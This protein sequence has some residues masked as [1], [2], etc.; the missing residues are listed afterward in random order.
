MTTFASF[1]A[2]RISIVATPS[3]IQPI[4]AYTLQVPHSPFITPFSTVFF[5][6]ECHHSTFRSIATVFLS[7]LLSPYTLQLLYWPHSVRSLVVR[8]SRLL[9]CNSSFSFTKFALILT[10]MLKFPCFCR[11]FTGA[12][13]ISFTFEPCFDDHVMGR[14]LLWDW[15]WITWGAHQFLELWLSLVLVLILIDAIMSM[16]TQLA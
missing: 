1:L 9:R 4:S 3:H 12:A 2:A 16:E 10:L 14:L 15:S 8:I 5:P 6:H 11:W 13:K 7:L